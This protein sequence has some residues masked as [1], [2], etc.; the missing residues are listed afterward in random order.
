MDVV[1]VVAVLDG[2]VTAVGAVVVRV[3][4]GHVVRPALPGAANGRCS[5]C[6]RGA[7][8]PRGQDAAKQASAS[9]TI[10]A[11]GAASR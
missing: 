2:E 7:R 3:V 9:S 8:T 10:V 4:L 11:P 5:R 1:D 6:R